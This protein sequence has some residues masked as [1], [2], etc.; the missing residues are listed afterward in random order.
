MLPFG[1]PYH[2]VAGR[3][4]T[5][6]LNVVADSDSG[7]GPPLIDSIMPDI[8]AAWNPIAAANNL[9][10]I[11]ALGPNTTPPVVTPSNLPTP[12]PNTVN[13][14]TGI[15][16]PNNVNFFNFTVG[17]GT[18][19]PRNTRSARLSFVNYQR[20]FGYIYQLPTTVPK[21]GGEI[22]HELGHVLGLSDRYYEAVFWLIDYA[23]NR[24]PAQIRAGQWVVGNNDMRFGVVDDTPARHLLPRLAIRATLPMRRPGETDYHNLMSTTD[25]SLDST[26]VDHILARTVEPT[27]RV[28]NW[29]VILGS[30][31]VYTAAELGAD[32][33][34][35]HAQ[36]EPQPKPPIPDW[37]MTA[38]PDLATN[39]VPLFP[40]TTSTD[41]TMWRYPSF[42]PT[43]VEGGS[44]VVF[45]PRGDSLHRYSCLALFRRGRDDEGGVVDPTRI[46]QA[47]GRRRLVGLHGSQVNMTTYKHPNWMAYARRMIR[48]LL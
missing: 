22:A 19:A 21:L 45:I 3:T 34:P 11:L 32:G 47:L 40:N 20:S 18:N 8:T 7:F 2:T 26:Q 15:T 35:S 44:G 5:I 1:P 9:T 29:V 13:V 25:S 46:G 28:R 10:V 17:H 24:T 36:L 16:P 27:Y 38:P 42:E 48:D 14:V 37:L 30:W 39:G 31:R 43:S 6:Y 12:A 23:V 33:V 41:L 4:I